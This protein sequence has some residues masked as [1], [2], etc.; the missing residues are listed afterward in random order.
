MAWLWGSLRWKTDIYLAAQAFAAVVLLTAVDTLPLYLYCRCCWCR[1]SYSNQQKEIIMHDCCCCSCFHCSHSA[2]A[3]HCKVTQQNSCT[4]SNIFSVF[5]TAATAAIAA[6]SA[7]L[8][9]CQAPWLINVNLWPRSCRSSH[10]TANSTC[11]LAYC[12]NRHSRALWLLQ[13][14]Y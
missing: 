8:S 11:C 10:N 9:L 5:S 6:A 12:Q 2:T 7:L 3:K 14:Y 4:A 1:C 13:L